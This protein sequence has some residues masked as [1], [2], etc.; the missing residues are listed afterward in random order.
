MVYALL[1]MSQ[2]KWPLS[3]EKAQQFLG[4]Y[5]PKAA[6]ELRTTNHPGNE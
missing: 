4:E 2:D 1:V 5:C 3:K 6:E